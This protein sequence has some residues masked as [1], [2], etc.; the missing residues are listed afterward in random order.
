MTTGLARARPLRFL[1]CIASVDPAQGGPIEGLKQL[2]LVYRL[3]GHTLEVVSLD[4]PQAPWVAQ[5]PFVVH[6]LGPGKLGQ[7]GYTPRLS[8][9]LR[10]HAVRFDVA[11][12]NGIWQFHAHGTARVLREVGL[13]YFVFTH[14]MLDP[15]FKRQY[16]LKHLKKWLFWP[17]ADYRVLR[18]AAAVL[19]TC[20]EERLRARESFWLYNAR[21]F[22]VDYGTRGVRGEAQQQRAAF[23]AR[24]PEL[25]DQRVLLFLGRMH[26]K[27]GAD[28]LLH[29][30]ARVLRERPDALTNTRLVM[31]G[32][33]DNPCGHALKQLADR[34]DLADRITWTGMLQGELKWGAFRVAD[35]F[36]LPSHQENF[37]I[38]VAEALS[39]GVP[40]LV[41]DQVNIWRE[42]HNRGAGWVQ[43]DTVDGTLA[44]LRQWLETSPSDMVSMRT[45]AR[46]CFERH[47]HIERTEASIME[48][49]ARFTALRDLPVTQPAPLDAALDR[50]AAGG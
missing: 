1:H 44:L 31:A 27:K 19:F 35:A 23:L 39:C 18:D 37:G 20:E 16:P 43:P 34:L 45:R 36:V 41:S 28:L 29:A 9:W 17:W 13:P 11:I 25:K 40:V 3:R 8:Q 2:A 22:V 6:A 33:A 42:I 4:D 46:A 49:V 26:E 12:I 30:W 32:P 14:G 7:Y 5:A 48:A 21:E 15:W 10:Q 24:Y 38:A 47:F 50:V